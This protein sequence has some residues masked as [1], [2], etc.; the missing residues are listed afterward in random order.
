MFTFREARI[1]GERDIQSENIQNRVENTRLEHGRILSQNTDRELFDTAESKEM[2]ET[3][4]RKTTEKGKSKK[5]KI[6]MRY[7]KSLFSTVSG[8]L[9][10][11]DY[12]FP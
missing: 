2:Q 1:S 11:S 4:K 6:R 7:W 12:R 3:S 10:S 8:S 5:P 9:G